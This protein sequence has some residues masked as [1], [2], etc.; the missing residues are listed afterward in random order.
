M[1]VG[2]LDPSEIEWNRVQSNMRT[3]LEE[4]G[5]NISKAHTYI[6][7]GKKKQTEVTS[8]KQIFL[9]KTV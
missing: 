6:Q 4:C 2:V 5:V 8:S 3:R 9:E 7:R 1:A